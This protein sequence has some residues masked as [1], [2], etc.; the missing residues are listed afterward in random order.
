MYKIY[1]HVPKKILILG[2]IYR[3][4]T[5]FVYV[6]NKKMLILKIYSLFISIDS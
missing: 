6:P 3:E 5:L 1:T 4:H 2:T